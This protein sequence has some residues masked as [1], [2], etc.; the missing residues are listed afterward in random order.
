MRIY[1]YFGAYGVLALA[2]QI[3]VI[4]FVIVFTI[5]MF[6]LI[7][8][9]KKEYFQSFWNYLEIFKLSFAW[10]AIG[11]FIYRVMV[12]QTTVEKMKNNPGKFFCD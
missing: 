8:R 11:F 2:S 3:V 9:G 10:V 4:I 12:I 5:R 7:I 1:E 6:I